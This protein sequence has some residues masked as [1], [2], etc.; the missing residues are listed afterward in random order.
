VGEAGIVV[1]R[2]VTGAGELE[3]LRQLWLVL[4]HH[5][6]RVQPDVPL[7]PDDDLSWRAR[8]QTYRGW[9]DD[10]SA[11]V[12]A[13]SIGRELVGYAV[14]HV[15]S[16][17]ADDTFDFG[18]TYAELYTLS[19]LPGRRGQGVGGTLLDALDELLRARSIATLT[20]AAMAG[21]SQALEFY[22]RRGFSPLE[23][24][25]RRQVPPAP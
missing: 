9:L 15:E 8:S 21:N 6:R 2:Q 3:T 10:G 16:G 17:V 11:L 20:V 12:L 24:T 22:R 14:A 4:H 13:A 23:V 19:V 25:L 7:Q 5:H 1:V 18:A